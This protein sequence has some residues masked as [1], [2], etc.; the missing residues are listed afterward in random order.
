[1]SIYYSLMV[2]ARTSAKLIWF[3]LAD[4]AIGQRAEERIWAYRTAGT[5]LHLFTSVST[6]NTCYCEF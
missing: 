4:S 6:L 2:M 3:W 1:M 5:N